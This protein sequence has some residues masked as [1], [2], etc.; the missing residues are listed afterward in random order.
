MS[1]WIPYYFLLRIIKKGSFL[2]LHLK[3]CRLNKIDLIFVL[4]VCISISRKFDFFFEMKMTKDFF[5][6]SFEFINFDI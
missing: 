2:K 1:I 5:F 3:I 4:G 6:E